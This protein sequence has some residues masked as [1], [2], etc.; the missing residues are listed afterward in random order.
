MANCAISQHDLTGISDLYMENE[1]IKIVSMHSPSSLSDC[2][3]GLLAEAKGEFVMTLTPGDEV[4]VHALYCIAAELNNVPQADLIYSDEDELDESYLRCRPNFKP[5]WNPLLLLSQNY[6]GHMVAYRRHRIY[7]VGGF[8]NIHSEMLEWDLALRISEV[9]EAT[10][11]RHIPR[12]LYHAAKTERILPRALGEEDSCRKAQIKVLGEHFSRVHRQAI[13]SE[14]GD[15]RLRIRHPLDD[16]VPLVSIIIP[17]RDNL[18]LLSKCISSVFEKTTYPNYELI[19]VDNQ[20]RDPR[21]LKYLH[22]LENKRQARVLRYD[23]PFN[24]SAIN[25]FAVQHAA[26]ELIALLNDDIEVISPDWLE[27][28]AGYAIQR[29]TGAV[30]AMLYYPNDTIQHAGVM[31]GMYGLAGCV[32]PGFARGHSGYQGRCQAPQNISAVIAACMVFRRKLYQEVNG[33]DE[34]LLVGCN[35]VDFCLRLLQKGYRNVWTP[36]A[37]LYHHESASRG[38]DDT[39]EKQIRVGMEAALMRQRWEAMLLHDPAYN[40]NLSLESSFALAFPPRLE[41]D[42]AR[43]G[44]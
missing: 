14:S 23:A 24:Y 12:V 28:M 13:I 16:P 26:G 32:Y 27:E 39:H 4:A 9:A 35:D 1:R 36:Y 20:S 17:T 19:V 43:G 25:N 11:I 33:L 34:K 22:E 10:N 31:L 7:Q 37:E 5:D 30:G 8:K 41:S 42:P 15:G 3:H 38:Y 18:N 21:L 44:V 40:P 6:I 2:L 29:E